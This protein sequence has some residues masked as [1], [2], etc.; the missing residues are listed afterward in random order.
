MESR[1]SGKSLVA[2]GIAGAFAKTCTNPLDRVKILCQAGTYRTAQEAIQ[3]IWRNEGIVGFWKGNCISVLR[4]IPS[5]GVLFMSSDTIK[6]YMGIS[7]DISNKNSP[8]KKYN[9]NFFQYVAAGS[10]SGALTVFLTYPLDLIRGRITSSIGNN[11]RYKS[12][13]QAIRITLMDEGIIAF[14]RGMS[15][16]LYGS[17]PYEGMFYILYSIYYY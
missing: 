15:T 10:L 4:I 11:S 3:Y 2:G 1:K 7:N 5:R 14:Y 13:F 17:L 8:Y 16:S 12:I 9:G 6:R